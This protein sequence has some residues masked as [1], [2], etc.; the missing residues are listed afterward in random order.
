[1]TDDVKEVSRF[2]EFLRKM[3]KGGALRA[4]FLLMQAFVSRDYVTRHAAYG[5]L[6]SL[7]CGLVASSM[8]G[9][10]LVRSLRHVH[11]A[12]L[13][14][15]LADEQGRQKREHAESLRLSSE[16][17]I[18]SFKVPINV[19]LD[20]AARFSS[21]SIAEIEVVVECDG[22][23]TREFINKYIELVRDQVTRTI[24]PVDR[25]EIMSPDG[26]KHLKT[27]IMKRLNA[28]LLRGRIKS[29]YFSK[30]IL[31]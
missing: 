27:I 17:S 18:G 25:E 16:L 7:S 21:V 6:L 30:F 28:W 22:T 1:M 23:E 29:I 26:K 11:E 24:L 20:N 15:E 10:R 19:P 9:V 2:Q 4:L 12:A 31:T 5:F 8:M 14:L 3:R 13:H